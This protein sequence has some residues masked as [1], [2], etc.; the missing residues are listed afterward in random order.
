M[1]NQQCPC[2]CQGVWTKMSLKIPSKPELFH[3]SMMTHRVFS[4]TNFQE[5]LQAV[6]WP[7]W[8]CCSS[9]LLLG[10]LSACQWPLRAPQMLLLSKH[11]RLQ[12]PETAARLSNAAGHSHP[13]HWPLSVNCSV[14][15]AHRHEQTIWAL[16]M[17]LYIA[18][19]I[20]YSASTTLCTTHDRAQC[21]L[22][23][24]PWYLSH[25][26]KFAALSWFN[27]WRRLHHTIYGVTAHS[28]KRISPWEKTS[29]DFSPTISRNAFGI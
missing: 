24:A 8:Q 26:S 29:Q 10:A 3:D 2:S 23:F 16:H 6:L 12:Q 20:N 25:F 27:T 14:T 9:H 5:Y 17:W 18:F 21:F 22:L 1:V 4:H 7:P 13:L 15:G 28:I 11:F 19:K